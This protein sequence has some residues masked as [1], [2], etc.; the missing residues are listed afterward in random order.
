MALEG[1]LVFLFVFFLATSV[2]TLEELIAFVGGRQIATD[3]AAAI[4]T[5]VFTHVAEPPETIRTTLCGSQS[6]S[7]PNRHL[8]RPAA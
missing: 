6:G 7:H 2:P 5:Y 3:D 4:G 8:C 1:D